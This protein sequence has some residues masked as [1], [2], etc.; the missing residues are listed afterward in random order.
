MNSI[1]DLVPYQRRLLDALADVAQ[2]RSRHLAAEPETRQVPPRRVRSGRRMA[3]ASVGAMGALTVGAV[4]LPAA[5]P[6]EAFAVERLDGNRV[7]VTLS[8]NFRDVGALQQA[9]DAEGVEMLVVA[10]E[11]CTMGELITVPGH[12]GPSPSAGT[13]GPVPSAGTP[14]PVPSAG[15][16]GP[17]P[18]AGTPGPVP[19]AGTPGP[20]PS[21]GTPGPVPSASTPGPVPSASTP[22]PSPSAST[23]APVVGQSPD[24]AVPP[25]GDVAGL[26][27]TKDGFIVDETELKYRVT[28]AVCP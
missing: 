26:T 24:V 18:S 22:G 25:V 21:A 20:V 19:S 13:P 3:M 14:G 10:G 8:E 27:R 28:V 11:G 5:T 17:V 1:D 2:E 4:L 23:H 9:L 6:S 15:T 7:E 16:P 12:G